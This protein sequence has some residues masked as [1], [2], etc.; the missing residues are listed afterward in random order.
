MDLKLF[1]AV[2]HA[3]LRLWPAD[4]YLLHADL[5]LCPAA[6]YSLHAD[7]RLG[8]SESYLLPTEFKSVHSSNSVKVLSSFHQTSHQQECYI[9][10][11]WSIR[12]GN[13]LRGSFR[14][15]ECGFAKVVLIVGLCFSI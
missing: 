1:Y 5:C 2:L 7:L 11:L 3:E 9:G 14:L 12:V 6:S 8:P 4:S 13:Y 15:G 10:V